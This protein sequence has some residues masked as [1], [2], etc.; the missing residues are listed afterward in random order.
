MMKQKH[1]N[2]FRKILA[3]LCMF[4]MIFMICFGS[5]AMSVNAKEEAKLTGSDC[6]AEKEKTASVTF[7]LEGNPGLWGLKFKVSY[8]HSALKLTS[9]TNG[10]VF[11]EGDVIPPENLQKE[12]YVFLASSGKLENISANGVVVTLNFI[13]TDEAAMQ[14]Y[15]ITAEITQV[16]DVDGNDVSMAVENGNITVKMAE[17]SNE[18][19]TVGEETKTG[20]NSNT[21]LWAVFLLISGGAIFAFGILYTRRICKKA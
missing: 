19:K 17:E 14:T 3:G 1:T 8:D 13:V 15:P 7:N 4:C 11:S 12:Q 21:V 9:V 10:T 2:G 16:I 20:D 18:D 6:T 5:K